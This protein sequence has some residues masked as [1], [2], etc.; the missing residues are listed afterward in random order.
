MPTIASYD[1]IKFI[2]DRILGVSLCQTDIP[3]ATMHCSIL[4]LDSDC[5]SIV[6]IGA[7]FYDSYYDK[8][9]C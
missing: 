3:K 9:N 8:S 4:E 5:L 1:I 6:F 2:R 7:L